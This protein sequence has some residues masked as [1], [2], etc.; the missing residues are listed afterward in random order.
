MNIPLIILIILISF[1]IPTFILILC[2][3]RVAA[4]ADAAMETQHE[5][6]GVANLDN[7]E[8]S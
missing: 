7:P 6:N 2:L 1:S 3:C 8:A 4:M 5:S